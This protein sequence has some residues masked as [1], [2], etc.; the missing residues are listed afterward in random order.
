MKTSSKLIIF[1]IGTVIFLITCKKQDDVYREFTVANGMIY[2]AKAANAVTYS[3]KN[4]IKIAWPASQDQSLVK[5]KIFWNNYTDSIEMDI[6]HDQDTISRIIE[7]LAENSYSFMIRTYDDKG[8]VSV[9]V[10]VSGRAYGDS[11]LSSIFTRSVN[12][13]LLDPVSGQVEISWAPA[14]VT[15]G[16]QATEVKYTDKEGVEKIISVY[17]E[18]SETAIPDLK[19]GTTFSCRTVYIPDSNYLDMFYTDYQANTKEIA[20][21]KSVMSVVSHSSQHDDGPNTTKNLLDGNNTGSRW[22]TATYDGTVFPH[23]VIIDFGGVTTISRFGV[24]A[25][26]VDQSGGAFDVRQPGRV[27]IET[28][29]DNL[30]WTDLG[31]HEFATELVQY[32]DFQPTL[33]RYFKFTGLEPGPL[34]NTNNLLVLGEFDFYN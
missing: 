12:S 29:L 3:G 30:V 21:K 23:Y 25:S 15:S 2:P 26:K 27:K 4:R 1:L 22:H 9:P 17:A 28:S 34:N 14:D 6:P 13:L 8:N 33:A 32:F 24:W 10:E 16:A 20:L 19:P 7:P 5:A 18:E 31:T 11:Y